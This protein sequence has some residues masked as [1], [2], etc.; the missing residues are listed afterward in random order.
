MA[1]AR[2][3]QRSSRGFPSLIVIRQKACQA[4]PRSF[5]E[6][7]LFP[8]PSGYFFSPVERGP[9]ITARYRQ[10][11]RHSLSLI[12]NSFWPGKNSFSLNKAFAP[13]GV[14]RLGINDNTEEKRAVH[15]IPPQRKQSC[16]AKSVSRT[17]HNAAR[18]LCDVA[19]YII[20]LCLYFF[21]FLLS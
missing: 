4:S 18:A 2:G 7:N 3:R 8:G 13:S 12:R 15:Y 14:F 5:T 20:I 17:L 1:G 21:V 16:Y 10:G 11:K 19:A 9:R 6:Q